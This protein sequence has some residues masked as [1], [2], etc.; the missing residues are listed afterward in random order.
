MLVEA[1]TSQFSEY[2]KTDHK[3][4]QACSVEK[5]MFWG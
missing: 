3:K 2:P 4:E 5:V 1:G